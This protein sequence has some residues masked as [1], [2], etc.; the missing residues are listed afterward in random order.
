MWNWDTT[1][2]FI[3]WFLKKEWKKSNQVRKIIFGELFVLFSCLK[4]SEKNNSGRKINKSHMKPSKKKRN[5]EENVVFFMCKNFRKHFCFVSMCET[6]KNALKLYLKADYIYI[7]IHKE[8]EDCSGQTFFSISSQ[9]I[10]TKR[11]N[12]LNHKSSSVPQW[13]FHNQRSKTQR[14]SFYNHEHLEPFL[15]LK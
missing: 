2:L 9:I 12:T 1:F 14:Y 3:D 7:Y 5:P 13:Y 6:R 11:E 4:A 8:L 15:S 10:N